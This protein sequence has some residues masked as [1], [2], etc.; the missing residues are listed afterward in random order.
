RLK[1][2]HREVQWS[3][4][5]AHRHDVAHRAD[6]LVCPRDL[7]VGRNNQDS[8]TL[9]SNINLRSNLRDSAN[10]LRADRGWEGRTDAVEAADVQEVRW[11]NRRRFHEVRTSAWPRAG[12]R[13]L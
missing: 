6:N 12:S 8:L 2:Y 4:T 13:T 1:H 7:L 3:G 5:V 11:I 9:Q 10:T